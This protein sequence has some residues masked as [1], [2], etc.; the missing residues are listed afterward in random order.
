MMESKKFP[1]TPGGKVL[2]WV[3]ECGLKFELTG[4][5]WKDREVECPFCGSRNV[6]EVRKEDAFPEQTCLGAVYLNVLTME[7]SMIRMV[8]HT[9]DP[10]AMMERH[11][12]LWDDFAEWAQAQDKTCDSNIPC[13]ARTAHGELGDINMTV[14]PLLIGARAYPLTPVRTGRGRA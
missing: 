6:E 7:R 10:E 1:R 5:Y 9:M 8:P 4:E 2:K 11:S 13:G 14:C 12:K 3:C